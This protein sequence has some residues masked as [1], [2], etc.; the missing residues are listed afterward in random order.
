[1]K[2]NFKIGDRA[3]AILD[4]RPGISEGMKLFSTWEWEQWRRASVRSGAYYLHESWK[5]KNIV[6]DE[7]I[8]YALDTALSGGTAKS[9]WYIAI[10]NDNHTP[11]AADDYAAPGYTESSAY[12]ESNRPQWQEAGVSSKVI[13]N[14]ANKASFTMNATVTIYGAA[15]VSNNTKGDTAASG[16]KMFCSSKFDSAKPCENTDV[17]KVTI[18]ITGSNV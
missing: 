15:L 6:V 8:E 4:R 7:G 16:E 2:S 12:T 5:T 17:L 9:T 18:T 10:F 1:M 3:E 14:T 11:V 13:T